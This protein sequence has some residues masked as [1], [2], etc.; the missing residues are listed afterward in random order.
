MLIAKIGKTVADRSNRSGLCNPSR[1]RSAISNHFVNRQVEGYD[2]PA[3]IY[4]R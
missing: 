1:F 4:E 2:F 3:Y